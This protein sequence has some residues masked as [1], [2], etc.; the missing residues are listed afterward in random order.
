MSF[1]VRLSR[2]S[3]SYLQRLPAGAKNRVLARLRELAEDPIGNSKRL[4]DAGQ[5]R[6]T[7]VGGLRIIL[8]I[9]LERQLVEVSYIG[10][11]GQ[12]YRR[13]R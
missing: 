6:S 10:P 12:V 8:T 11:R 4:Q 1:E 3:A 7:R 5:R 13:L 9:D 2:D